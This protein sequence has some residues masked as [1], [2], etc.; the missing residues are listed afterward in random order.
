MRHL[1][2]I[3]VVSMALVGCAEETLGTAHLLVP[4]NI[5]LHWDGSFNAED[6]GLGALVPV[7][8]MVYDSASG[9][10]W[11]LVPFEISADQALFIDANSE[12][13]FEP[14]G[15]VDDCIWDV[16][17]DQPV[18]LMLSEQGFGSRQF[19]T[20]SSGLARVYVYVD[21]FPSHDEG[22]GALAVHVRLGMIDE[23][24]LLVP[25]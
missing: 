1:T 5:E 24:F 2:I 6:D 25:R 20:D 3:S 19:R 13:L 11:A 4:E 21:S 10:P 12:V 14:E 8:L 18:E 16:W 15:C 7:D 23:T 9:E 22:F 17:R